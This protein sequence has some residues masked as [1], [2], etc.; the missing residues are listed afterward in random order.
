[1]GTLLPLGLVDLFLRPT[2]PF[3]Y[4][5]LP[6]WTCHSLHEDAA[7]FLAMQLASLITLG[8]P[9][10]FLYLLLH[11]EAVS[12]LLDLLE[13]IDSYLELPLPVTFLLNL[14]PPLGPAT[15]FLDL[16]IPEPAIPCLNMVLP[17]WTCRSL[18]DH[19]LPSMLPLLKLLIPS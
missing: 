8:S 2:D 13:H 17:I 14:L 3:L 18:L 11:D 4:L 16:L 12:S 1:M 15:L 6:A 10:F 19:G 7:P 9:A 5:L